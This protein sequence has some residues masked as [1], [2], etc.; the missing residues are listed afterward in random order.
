MQ[1][2]INLKIKNRESF[3][4]F[5]PA[6]LAEYANEWFDLKASSPYM[7]IVSP[8]RDDKK[9]RQP[10]DQIALTGLDKAKQIRADIPAV[11]HVDY[12][13]RI[14]TVD[15]TYHPR[16][17]Q[18]IEAFRRETGYPL[19]IN[20]SFNVRGEPIVESPTDAFTCFM[21]TD[22]DYLVIG[23]AFLKKS[24]QNVWTE[25]T[26]WKKQFELD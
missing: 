14:Q 8:L 9:N 13:A 18:L 6:I 17:H 21:R 7:L 15:G 4:P 20:T 24:E 1:R 2:I 11:I 22:M 25:K 12:S 26:D 10:S 23:S 5:A 19:L 3:R 16:F